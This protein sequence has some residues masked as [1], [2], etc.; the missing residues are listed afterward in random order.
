MKFVTYRSTPG[1]ERYPENERFAV[2]REAHHHLMRA[3]YSYARQHQAYLASVAKAS[4]LVPLAGLPLGLGIVGGVAAGFFHWPL[5]YGA[6]GI[7]AGVLL[8]LL[9]AAYIC[10]MAFE[11]QAFMNSRVAAVLRERDAATAVSSAK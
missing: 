7:A 6:G 9:A 10:R 1:L 2:W 11:Q 3:D 5:A 8:S 4:G